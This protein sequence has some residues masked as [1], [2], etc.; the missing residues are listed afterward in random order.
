MAGLAGRALLAL[1]GL[2]FSAFFGCLGVMI[3]TAPVEDDM[4]LAGWLLRGFIGLIFGAL[5]AGGLWFTV[6][7][8]RGVRPAGV[9]AAVAALCPGCGERWPE[10]EAPCSCG[11]PRAAGRTWQET[12]PADGPGVMLFGAAFG[13]GILCLGLFLAVHALSGDEKRGLMIVAYLGLAALLSGVGGL[14]SFGALAGARDAFRARRTTR[15]QADWRGDEPG[16]GARTILATVTVDG[17]S[18]R[19]EGVTTIDLPIE[20]ALA[21]EA[22]GAELPPERRALAHVV[23]AL[24]A[25]GEAGLSYVE[26]RSFQTEGGAAPVREA[27][28]DVQ[29]D[30]SVPRGS[31]DARDVVLLALADGSVCAVAAAAASSPEL[32]AALD[33]FAGRLT[34]VD[35]DPRV[36]AALAR[37]LRAAP[38]PGAPY[39][40]SA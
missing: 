36:L 12:P 10:G 33:T 6:T 28:G 29:I 20:A 22:S 14:M 31:I 1:G 19:A 30:V 37:V 23:A 25:R 15:M 18:L 5:T 34:G 2:A 26:R 32:A 21:A 4:I 16:G 8:L 9:P 38:A 35:L 13:G 7:S 17:A 24:H 39:R 27:H 3:V 11:A 40:V